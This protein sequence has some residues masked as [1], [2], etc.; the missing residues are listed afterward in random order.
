MGNLPN[1]KIVGTQT[2]KN[3]QESL[4]GE[5]RAY[6]KYTWYESKAVDDGYVEVSQVFR[7]TADNEKEHAEI[8]FKYLGG[9]EGTKENLVA[10]AGGEN[11]EWT[12]MYDGFAKT[13]DKEGFPDIAEMFR[14]LASI[15]KTHEERYRKYI[16]TIESGKMLTG[17][18]STSKWI[19]LNCGFIYEGADAPEHWPTCGYPRGYFKLKTEQD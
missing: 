14:R 17:A 1:P 10:A 13:A 3:L 2:E 11:Y 6:L 18:E 12:T 16:A 9:I 4:S 8:W 5:S 15:E 7:K 19:C